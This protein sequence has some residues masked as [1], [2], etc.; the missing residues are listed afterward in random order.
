MCSDIDSYL[1]YLGATFPNFVQVEEIGRSGE[2]RPMKVVKLHQETGRA[3]KKAILLD[4][5]NSALFY[6]RL[7]SNYKSPTAGLAPSAMK[8]LQTPHI[9]RTFSNY[10]F[11]DII[12]VCV[13]L[14]IKSDSFYWIMETDSHFSFKLNNQ[15][16][17]N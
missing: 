7:K 17:L 14:V 15:N 16:Y 5:G 2:G 12:P 9:N 8:P 11:I 1:T 6:E 13:H 4:S 3:N 10:Y